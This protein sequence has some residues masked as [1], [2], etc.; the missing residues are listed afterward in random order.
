MHALDCSN[1]DEVLPPLLTKP[2]CCCVC[3][4]P[5]ERPRP[6]VLGVAG[7]VLLLGFPFVLFGLARF[8]QWVT[9]TTGS[10]P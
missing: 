3:G 7:L 5:L 8:I 6:N 2:G 4:V 1:K 9:V 10:V